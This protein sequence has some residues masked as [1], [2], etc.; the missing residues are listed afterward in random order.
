[1]LAE[2]EEVVINTVQ[3]PV[4]VAQEVEALVVLVAF[5]THHPELMALLI[6]EAVAVVG[7]TYSRVLLAVV[8][9]VS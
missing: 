3:P 1:M 8:V 7:Q 6:L 2:A 4:L 5:H 9:R